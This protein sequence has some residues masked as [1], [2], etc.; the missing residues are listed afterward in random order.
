MESSSRF[1]QQFRFRICISYECQNY[2]GDAAELQVARRLSL[3][4]NSL[5]NS[6]TRKPGA[7]PAQAGRCRCTRAKAEG[8]GSRPTTSQVRPILSKLSRAPACQ[9]RGS[10]VKASL[11]KCSRRSELRSIDWRGCDR[12]RLRGR[13]LGRRRPG[14]S[15]FPSALCHS[16]CHRR[17]GSS[18]SCHTSQTDRSSRGVASLW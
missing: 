14:L 17:R 12:C 13:R 1:P 3:A 6:R 2:P 5:L 16:T 9:R 8:K 7:T 11:R 10:F 15:A 4:R 18:G